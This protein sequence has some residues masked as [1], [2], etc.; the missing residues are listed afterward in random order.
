M[1]SER[2]I[3]EMNSRAISIMQFYRDGYRRARDEARM[4]A[5]VAEVAAWYRAA[6]VA[7]PDLEVRVLRPI[8][9]ELADRYGTIVGPRLYAKFRAAFDGPDAA[10]ALDPVACGH[11]SVDASRSGKSP[12]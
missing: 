3:L 4:V 11:R 8:A 10:T 2:A 9:A 7:G 12:N 5:E 6:N 1:V